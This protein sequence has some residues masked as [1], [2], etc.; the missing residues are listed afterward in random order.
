MTT[1]PSMPTVTPEPVVTPLLVPA[2]YLAG[3]EVVLVTV[4]GHTVDT[5]RFTRQGDAFIPDGWR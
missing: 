5:L 1:E 2:V 3:A 4:Y